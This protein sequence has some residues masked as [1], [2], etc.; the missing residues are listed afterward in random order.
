VR[1]GLGIDHF[2]GRGYLGWH[3]HGTLIVLAG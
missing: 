2:D 3:R 1:T